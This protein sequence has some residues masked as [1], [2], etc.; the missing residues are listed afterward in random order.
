MNRC[1]ILRGVPGCGKTTLSLL[2][3]VGGRISRVLSTDDFFFDGKKYKFDPERLAEAFDRNLREFLDTIWDF[4]KRDAYNH[5]IF[6]SNTSARV[7]EIAPYYAI[8]KAYGF[9][10]TIVTIDISV[11]TAL[12]RNVH[13]VPKATIEKTHKLMQDEEK[14][15]PRWWDHLLI[16]NC[17]DKTPK[18]IVDII[19]MYF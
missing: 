10:P 4:G 19:R 12:E 13:D 9:A 14:M 8:A 2:L 16:E 7:A 11:E 5:I 18:Q 17:D 15:F 1:I 3:S 6:V